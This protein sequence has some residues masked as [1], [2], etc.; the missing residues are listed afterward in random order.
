MIGVFITWAC[1]CALTWSWRPIWL[2]VWE[3]VPGGHPCWYQLCPEEYPH[4][5]GH[6]VTAVEHVEWSLDLGLFVYCP[7]HA[8]GPLKEIEMSYRI[9]NQRWKSKCESI[10][11]LIKKSTICFCRWLNRF[12]VHIPCI[13]PS[14]IFRIYH[15]QCWTSTPV[16]NSDSDQQLCLVASPELSC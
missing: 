4:S 3:Q 11:V 16:A 1:T 13:L 15:C 2:F 6:E 5:V 14:A 8:C 7:I 9:L 10:F 12:S